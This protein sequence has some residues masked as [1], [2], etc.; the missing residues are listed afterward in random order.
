MF[1]LHWHCL[2][3]IYNLF[4]S[5]NAFLYD[6][7]FLLMLLDFLSSILVLNYVFLPIFLCLFL[8]LYSFRFHLLYFFLIKISILCHCHLAILQNHHIQVHLFYH[9]SS[10]HLYIRILLVCNHKMNHMYLFYLHHLHSLY[11]F[12]PIY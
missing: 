12:Y 8:F 11:I 10:Y 2:I 9:Q 3:M 4:L 1:L 5:Y 6:Y 7:T